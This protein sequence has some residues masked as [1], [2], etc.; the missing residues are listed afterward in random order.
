MIDENVIHCLNY[1]IRGEKSKD[2]YSQNLFVSHYQVLKNLLLDNVDN[3]FISNAIINSFYTKIKLESVHFGYLMED[4]KFL[5]FLLNYSA[6][7][8]SFIKNYSDELFELKEKFSTFF[9]V[10]LINNTEEIISNSIVEALIEYSN[11]KIRFVPKQNVTPSDFVSKFNHKFYNAKKD[12]DIFTEL[13]DKEYGFYIFNVP[14]SGLIG[15][16]LL[17]LQ[18]VCIVSHQYNGTTLFNLHDKILSKKGMKGNSFSLENIIN[19]K[20]D[21]SVNV[22]TFDISYMKDIVTGKGIN[23]DET[24][25]F[26]NIPFLNQFNLISLMSLMSNKKNR[27]INEKNNVA[28]ISQ[29]LDIGSNLP[30]LNSYEINEI[31]KFSFD[32]LRFDGEY[33]FLSF[34][35]DLFEDIIDM[36]T[37][38]FYS[39]RDDCYFIAELNEVDKDSAFGGYFKETFKPTLF[40]KDHF[41]NFS[42]KEIPFPSGYSYAHIENNMNHITPLN[43]YAVGSKEDIYK[44]AFQ[45]AKMNKLTLYYLYITFYSNIYYSKFNNE[46]KDFLNDNIQKIINDDDLICKTKTSGFASNSRIN[47]NNVTNLGSVLVAP[48]YVLENDKLK[49]FNGKNKATHLLAWSFDNNELMTILFEKYHLKLSKNAKMIF[50]FN[51]AFI[52]LATI[53][54]ELYLKNKNRKVFFGSDQSEIDLE[55]QGW[56]M[57]GSF[58]TAVVP[59]TTSQYK[60]TIEKFELLNIE[61]QDLNYT[62]GSALFSK[63]NHFI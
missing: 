2:R 38:N 26:S 45:K 46:I 3:P 12:I 42:V 21:I 32:D 41:N 33:H 35:D 54:K 18:S 27:Y 8:D 13:E 15:H 11:M 22:N 53:Y 10:D 43:N 14:Y 7:E 61:V 17:E 23:D 24:N 37:V 56:F 50:K 57:T 62:K 39:D 36:D 47:N 31:P 19:K 34:L 48:E 63:E 30:I 59:L 51:N 44:K 1:F 25:I 60:S 29:N 52:Q 4:K 6:F 16:S 5:N 28:Q 9:N 20:N 40:N 58:F 49:D 55:L